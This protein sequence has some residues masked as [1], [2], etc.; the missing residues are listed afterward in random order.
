VLLLF[1]HILVKMSKKVLV[2]DDNPDILDVIQLILE[3]EGYGVSCLKDGTQLVDAIVSY[4]PNLILL[5]IMLGEFDGRDLC[6]S[7][8]ENPETN[9]IPIIMISASH[10]LLS[11]EEKNCNAEAF[12]GKPFEIDDLIANV[13]RLAS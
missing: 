8:K 1:F 6:R 5:D 12:I 2:V 11:L 10:G 4:R 13:D 3:S 9:H 7:L